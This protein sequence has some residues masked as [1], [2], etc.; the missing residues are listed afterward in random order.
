MQLV[1]TRPELRSAPRFSTLS[2][3]LTPIN[4]FY[5]TTFVKTYGPDHITLIQEQDLLG[6]SLTHFHG[7]EQVASSFCSSISSPVK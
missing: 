2:T 3:A 4:S 7:Y 5:Q 6:Q 1:S